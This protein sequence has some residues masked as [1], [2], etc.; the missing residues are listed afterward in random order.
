MSMIP[1]GAHLDPEQRGVVD[2]RPQGTVPE[3]E[4][5]GMDPMRYGSC[6][7]PNP[8]TGTVGCK[9][10]HRCRM[11]FRGRSGPENVGIEIAKKDSDMPMPRNTVDC[12]WV[13]EH[14]DD[15][16]ANGGAVTV[17][18]IGGETYRKVD[19]VIVHPVTREICSQNVPGCER[20][21]R[22]VDVLVPKYPRPG[23]VQKHLYDRLNSAAR[24]QMKGEIEREQRARAY[25]LRAEEPIDTGREAVRRRKGQ[26]PEG[27][28]DAG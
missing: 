27:V 8:R 4:A 3:M 18:A 13:A 6:A 26:K 5:A 16:V 1:Q 21:L 15:I 20:E 7:A 24:E 14:R 25:D 12:M 2:A 19:T 10:F 28:A 22:E 11:S 23:E 17:L 9:D